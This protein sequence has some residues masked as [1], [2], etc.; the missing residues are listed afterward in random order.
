MKDLA[1]TGS[2]LNAP[3][4]AKLLGDLSGLAKIAAHAPDKSKMGLEMAGSLLFV[5][6]SLEHIH[7][8]PEHFSERADELASRLL[9]VVSG[10]APANQATWLG[11]I[12]KQAQQKQTMSVLVGEMQNSLRQIEKSLDEYFRDHAKKEIL[13]TVNSV[14]HQLGGALAILDQDEAMHAV[15]HTRQMVNKFALES[16]ELAKDADAH[17]KVAQNVGALSFFIETLQNQPEL[18][19]RKFHLIQKPAYLA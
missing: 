19:K 11:D 12:S 17:K 3:A 13:T 15:E 8:L 2:A 5:E 9:S 14:L 18:A 7:H 10:D 4:L 16:D 1:E 6:N